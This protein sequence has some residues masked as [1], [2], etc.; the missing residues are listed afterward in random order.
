MLFQFLQG[1]VA[2]QIYNLTRYHKKQ[3]QYMKQWSQDT[4]YMSK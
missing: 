2:D 3:I 1:R 4:R